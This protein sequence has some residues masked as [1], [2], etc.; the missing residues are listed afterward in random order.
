MAGVLTAT[1]TRANF[2]SVLDDAEAGI[3]VA[4]SRGNRK[5]ALVDAERLRRTLA[6]LVVPDVQMFCEAGEWGAFVPAIPS[7]SATGDTLA[8]VS[9]DLVA[10]A[11]EYAVDWND[12]LRHA[13]NHCE[14][15]GFVQVILLSTDAELHDW[16][17]P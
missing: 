17:F 11:R 16:L 15:W 10:A 1:E 3:S 7:I 5:S 14:N 4:V 2:K 13:P 9:D 12:F 6:S 8:E